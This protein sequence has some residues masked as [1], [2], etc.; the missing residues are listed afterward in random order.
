M[1][2]DAH[3]RKI[4]MKNGSSHMCRLL[5]VSVSSSLAVASP[6]SVDDTLQVKEDAVTEDVAY[7]LLPSSLL[8]VS[9]VVPYPLSIIVLR[10]VDGMLLVGGR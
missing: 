8:F 5:I 7:P 6:S 3:A 2:N 9:D 4:L 1:E 10:S